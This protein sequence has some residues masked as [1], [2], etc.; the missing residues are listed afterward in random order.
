MLLNRDD[1]DIVG[2][3]D[4]D[5]RMVDKTKKI[6]ES[7]DLTQPQYYTEGERHYLDMLDKEKP[8]L[9]I[10]ATPWRWHTEMAIECLKRNIYPWS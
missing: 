3:A 1:I 9:A 2:V 10:I 6:F 8:D 4:I 7:R 5:P